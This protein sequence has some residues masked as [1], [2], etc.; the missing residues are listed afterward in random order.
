MGLDSVLLDR[1]RLV[2][3]AAS[4]TKAGGRTTFVETEPGTWFPARLSLPESMPEGQPAGFVSKRV[5]KTPTLLCATED[6]IG[7]EVEVRFNDMLEVESEDLGS[8]T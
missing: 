4:G 7:N 5:V 2:R 1:A 8:A 3:Q 6:D